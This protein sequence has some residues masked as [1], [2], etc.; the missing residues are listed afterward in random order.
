MIHR[1][2]KYAPWYSKRYLVRDVR[3]TFKSHSSNA[4]AKTD[5]LTVPVLTC[6]MEPESYGADIPAKP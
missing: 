6:I 4:Q 2:C 5:L 3:L 1:I